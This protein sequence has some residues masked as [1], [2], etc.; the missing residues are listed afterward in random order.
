VLQVAGASAKGGGRLVS[1]II[2]S[3]GGSGVG[4]FP[5]G[6]N[7]QLVEFAIALQLTPENSWSLPVFTPDMR[8]SL[9]EEEKKPVA[10]DYR[11]GC[12]SAVKVTFVNANFLGKPNPC[13]HCGSTNTR[14]KK[15]VLRREADGDS[16]QVDRYTALNN[17]SCGV[18]P[19]LSGD[20]HRRG[21]CGLICVCLDTDCK[22]EFNS[23][24]PGSLGLWPDGLRFKHLRLVPES[25][26][27]ET[28]SADLEERC[29]KA[30]TK[31]PSVYLTESGK[32]A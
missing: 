25:G 3:K 23:A 27:R 19:V 31:M 30:G 9:D 21:V 26:L 5:G 24:S 10:D 28:S 14:A 15:T 29:Q 1:D 22:K 12:G 16:F 32:S 11:F 17:D 4:S 2:A 20:G 6:L 18:T 13:A 7:E 8:W